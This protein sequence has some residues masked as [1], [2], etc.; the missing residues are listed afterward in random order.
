MTN[1][2]PFLFLWDMVEKLFVYIFNDLMILILSYC[3]AINQIDWN[4]HFPTQSKLDMVL[5]VSIKLKKNDKIKVR[6]SIFLFN[7]LWVQYII[8]QSC[9][10]GIT[11]C[12]FIHV[13]I[14]NRIMNLWA[15]SCL[16]GISNT[17][18]KKPNKN[19]FCTIL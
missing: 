5:I 9:S 17:E 15:C 18:K 1:I 16:L 2:E 8:R 3:F 7:N 12:K 4:G 6:S 13:N 19:I 11:F 10:V 14:L